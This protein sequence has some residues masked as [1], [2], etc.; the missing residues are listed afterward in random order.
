MVDRRTMALTNRVVFQI[1]RDGFKS[2]FTSS[3]IAEV[4]THSKFHFWVL[5]RIFWIH[6]CSEITLLPL[7]ILSQWPWEMGQSWN[8]RDGFRQVLVHLQLH[9]GGDGLL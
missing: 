4:M 1:F 6:S 9:C 3:S 8:F 2:W 7:R 5:S